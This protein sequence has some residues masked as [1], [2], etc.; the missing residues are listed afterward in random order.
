MQKV[1]VKKK[2]P[3]PTEKLMW[4]SNTRFQETFTEEQQDNWGG[5]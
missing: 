4:N 2:V 1:F 5:Q 3:G